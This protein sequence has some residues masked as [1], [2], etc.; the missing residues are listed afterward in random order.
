MPGLQNDS[1]SFYGSLHVH[2]VHGHYRPENRN[3]RS[4]HL[5]SKLVYIAR[6]IYELIAFS[7]L[8]L[9]ST[10]VI[11]L[12]CSFLYVYTVLIKSSLPFIKNKI[13]VC[14]QPDQVSKKR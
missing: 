8:P 1:K 13:A 3:W 7:Y 2:S 12:S 9:T 10:N 5:K 11:Y 14:T 4:A 6:E